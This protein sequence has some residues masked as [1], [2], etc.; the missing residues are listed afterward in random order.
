M[1]I[2]PKPDPCF[3]GHDEAYLPRISVPIDAAVEAVKE[4]SRK[5]DLTNPGPAIDAILEDARIIGLGEGSHGTAEYFQT[6]AEITK[7]LIQARNAR[8]VMVELPRGLLKS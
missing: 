6:Q 2:Q 3:P 5:I 7:Y 4:H 1:H 8:L